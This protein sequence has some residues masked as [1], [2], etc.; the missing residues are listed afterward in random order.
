MGKDSEVNN[1]MGRVLC[2]ADMVHVITKSQLHYQESTN[3]GIPKMARTVPM[4]TTRGGR[5]VYVD[6][7]NFQNF[8]FVG[9][10]EMGVIR[11]K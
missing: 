9:I 7:K 10:I 4:L 2:G 3:P 5:P 1:R 8:E 11:S 6:C